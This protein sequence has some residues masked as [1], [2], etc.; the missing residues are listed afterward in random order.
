M[1]QLGNSI[2][3][4]AVGTVLT[5]L[6]AGVSWIVS[7]LVSHASRL[8]ALEEW[9]DEMKGATARIEEKLDRL[10]EGRWY[11]GRPHLH[12]PPEDDGPKPA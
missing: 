12:R 11:V 4:V 2:F 5:L 1:E 8:S 3:V 9:K 7:T 10:V 6:A